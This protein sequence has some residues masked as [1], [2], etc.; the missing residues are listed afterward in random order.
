GLWWL[1]ASVSLAVAGLL[2]LHGDR[3]RLAGWI[4]SAVL[5]VPAMVVTILAVQNDA[6]DGSSF[7]EDFDAGEMK[8][9][10]AVESSLHGVAPGAWARQDEWT[11]LR[12][13][14]SPGCLDDLGRTRGAES[15]VGYWTIGVDL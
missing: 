10:G 3:W 14:L 4:V 1:P 8:L 11:T 13:P 7:E 6:P 12:N 2:T 9:V 5:L 15:G